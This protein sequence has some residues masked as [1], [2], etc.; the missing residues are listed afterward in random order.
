MIVVANA[1]PLA[2]LM[3]LVVVMIF[4]SYLVTAPPTSLTTASY[5]VTALPTSLTTASLM[6][7]VMMEMMLIFVSSLVTATTKTL[8]HASLMALALTLVNLMAL[9]KIF[10][11][12]PKAALPQLL[13]LWELV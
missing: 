10:V 6:A 2:N 3:A 4:A 1:L 8:S 11:K 12:L 7:L 13:Q 5:L 9:V